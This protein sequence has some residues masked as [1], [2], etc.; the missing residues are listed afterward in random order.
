M[1]ITFEMNL[2][3]RFEFQYKNMWFALFP[4]ILTQFV[5]LKLPCSFVQQLNRVRKKQIEILKLL[6]L[7]YINQFAVNLA[8]VHTTLSKCCINAL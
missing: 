1:R 6:P 2:I 5:I 7:S 3:D 4:K 8:F